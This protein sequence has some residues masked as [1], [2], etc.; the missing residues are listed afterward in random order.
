MKLYSLKSG[1]TCSKVVFVLL[2]LISLI[3]IQADNAD[4]LVVQKAQ[5]TFLEFGSTTCVPCKMMEKVLVEVKDIY[6]DRIDVQFINVM[7][8]RDLAQ[9]YGI[10]LIP[11]QVFLDENKNEISRHQGYFPTAE[12]RK[13]LDPYLRRVS[14]DR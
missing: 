8:N 14:D 10:K 4:S 1:L 13:I 7:K 6:G 9:E 12:I 3:T 5:L 2:L 11:T